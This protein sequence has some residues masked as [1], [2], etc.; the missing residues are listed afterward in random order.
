M[1]TVKVS[2]NFNKFLAKNSTAVQ[3]VKKA[4]NTMQTC[5]MPVGWKGNV[6]VVGGEADKGKDR[7]DDKG[8]V[9]EGREYVRLDF[10]V[11]NDAEFAGAKC[12]LYWSFYDSEKATAMDRFQWMLNEMENLGLPREIRESDDTTM[13]DLLK[14]FTEQDSIYEAE[15]VHNYRS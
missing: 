3:E 13:E 11:V 7:K 6:I 14:F 9:Q 5:K 4:E 2:S 1:A 15:V 8:Q 12:S 10:N